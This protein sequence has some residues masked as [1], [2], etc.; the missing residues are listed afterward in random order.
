MF[1]KCTFLLWTEQENLFKKR[2]FKNEKE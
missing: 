2:R 1:Q